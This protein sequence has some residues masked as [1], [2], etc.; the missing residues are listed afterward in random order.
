MKNYIFLFWV[1]RTKHVIAA[2][3][4]QSPSI[5]KGIAGQARNDAGN[6]LEMARAQYPA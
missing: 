5:G 4:P 1:N 6:V 3:E 2:S